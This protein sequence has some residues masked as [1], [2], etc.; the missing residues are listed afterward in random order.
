MN[1]DKN[2]TNSVN[3]VNA[4]ANFL[5]EVEQTDYSTNKTASGALT[6]QQST[7]NNLRR[8]GL[9]ALVNDL[10]AWLPDFDIVETKD[11][12]VIVAENEPGDFTFSWELKSTIKSIDYD[13]FIAAN[14]WE[15]KQIQDAAKK[16]DRIKRAKEKQEALEEK[17]KKKLKTLENK[18]N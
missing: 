3:S 13:P 15:E 6:I 5:H 2:N 10:K 12:I 4:F 9:K 8:E 14:N 7:R 18:D 1:N 16:A 11:G 17:R